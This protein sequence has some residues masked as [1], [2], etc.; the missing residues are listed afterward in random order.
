MTPVT[1]GAS[2]RGDDTPRSRAGSSSAGRPTS[3]QRRAARYEGRWPVATPRVTCERTRSRRR[4]PRHAPAAF[5]P[6]GDRR[7]E[8]RWPQLRVSLS[9]S[10][11][12]AASCILWTD[13]GV[14][15]QVGDRPPT[16]SSRT[17][18]SDMP[19][20]VPDR[21]TARYDH[22]QLLATLNERQREAVT[23]PD[24]PNPQASSCRSTATGIAGSRPPKTTIRHSWNRR[25][26]DT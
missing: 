4:R 17:I 7:L 3:V 6:A 16:S 25:T 1:V 20:T 8:A 9:N 19:T 11:C 15:G 24:G 12:P 18:P 14:S 22:E 21:S 13:L 10:Q 5:A 2:R 26:A 23:V